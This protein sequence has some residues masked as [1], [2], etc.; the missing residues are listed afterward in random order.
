MVGELHL[1]LLGLSIFIAIAIFVFLGI[2][3]IYFFARDIK[4]VEQ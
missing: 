4:S 3:A 2:G 1:W